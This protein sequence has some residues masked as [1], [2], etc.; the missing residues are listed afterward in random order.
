MSCRMQVIPVAVVVSGVRPS[1]SSLGVCSDWPMS[2]A[3]TILRPPRTVDA[4]DVHERR[5]PTRG[6]P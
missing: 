5:L 1:Q 4:V 6:S 3:C 2:Q